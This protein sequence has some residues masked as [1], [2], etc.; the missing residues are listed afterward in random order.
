MKTSEITRDLLV[1]HKWSYGS[2]V[3]RVL[4]LF[5]DDNNQWVVNVEWQFIE[6]VE[7]EHVAP[8]NIVKFT[9]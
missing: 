5:R 9:G 6:G 3:G 7:V 2:V 1:T 4:G 8:D